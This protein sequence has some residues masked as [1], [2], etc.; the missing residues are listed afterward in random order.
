[1]FLFIIVNLIGSSALFAVKLIVCWVF[2]F[3]ITVNFLIVE[4]LLKLE[5]F[6]G[7]GVK[8]IHSSSTNAALTLGEMAEDICKR[9]SNI[10]A[11]N[12]KTNAR[13][14]HGEF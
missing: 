9:V 3:V 8:M 6:Y 5:K 13:P 4:M 12:K 7:D 11:V 10:F 14:C 2:F 1:M